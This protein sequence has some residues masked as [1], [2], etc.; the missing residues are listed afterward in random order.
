MSKSLERIAD[1][2][3]AIRSLLELLVMAQEPEPPAPAPTECQHPEESRADFG[4][5]NGLPEWE[6]RIC[7]YRTPTS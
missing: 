2:L 3:T 4:M 5:T 6:C 1:E 7:G